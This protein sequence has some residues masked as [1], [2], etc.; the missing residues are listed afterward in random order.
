MIW[1]AGAGGSQGHKASVFNYGK[2]CP[3]VFFRLFDKSIP[4]QQYSE[5][6]IKRASKIAIN[7]SPA[8]VGP[9]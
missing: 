5:S 3:F 2:K 9:K 7:F 4:T 6:N 1:A 8:M